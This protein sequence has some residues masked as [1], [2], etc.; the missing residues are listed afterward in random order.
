[1]SRH[2]DGAAQSDSKVVGTTIHFFRFQIARWPAEPSKH[3]AFLFEVYLI[4]Q[5]ATTSFVLYDRF[6]Y[7]TEQAIRFFLHVVT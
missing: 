7:I 4:C 5:I 2:Q 1:M 6:A 3:T